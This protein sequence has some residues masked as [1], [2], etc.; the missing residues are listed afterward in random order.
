MSNTRRYMQ[1]AIAPQGYVFRDTET[2]RILIQL[3]RKKGD[4]KAP[5]WEMVCD[6]LKGGIEPDRK[7]NVY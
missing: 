1:S 6:A 5:F 4:T 7:P 3:D 2:D